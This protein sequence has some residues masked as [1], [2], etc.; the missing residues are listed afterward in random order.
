MRLHPRSPTVQPSVASWS[1]NGFSTWKYSDIELSV[2]HTPQTFERLLTFGRRHVPDILQF[3]L[4]R[5]Q[6]GGA[7]QIQEPPIWL[8][9]FETQ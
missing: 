7:R 4:N 9:S 5:R 8:A 3:P 6:I 1:R 2:Q